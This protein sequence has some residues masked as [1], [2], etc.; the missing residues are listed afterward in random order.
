MMYI[1]LFDVFG[2]TKTFFCVDFGFLVFMT[3]VSLSELLLMPW[4]N[5]RLRCEVFDDLCLAIAI[6]IRDLCWT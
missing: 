3:L 1:P 6:T 4:S 2:K 5:E